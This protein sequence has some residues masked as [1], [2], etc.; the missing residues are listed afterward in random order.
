MKSPLSVIA[1]GVVVHYIYFHK[2]SMVSGMENTHQYHGDIT[3]CGYVIYICLIPRSLICSFLYPRAIC[4][5][6]DGKAT[7]YLLPKGEF[8]LGNLEHVVF[9]IE[10]R[11]SK[12]KKKIESFILIFHFTPYK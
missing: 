6:K 12:K 7:A 5:I 10:F 4:D 11:I 3:S 8:F 1:K 2:Q 9:Q